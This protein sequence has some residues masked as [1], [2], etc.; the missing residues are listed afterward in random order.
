[1]CGAQL[2]VNELNI[3]YEETIN[4]GRDMRL[5]LTELLAEFPAQERPYAWY[6]Q[7]SATANIADDSLADLDVVFGDRIIRRGIWPE[8]SPDLTA[9]N[10]YLSHN[11]KGSLQNESAYRRRIERKL[12]KEVIEVPQEEIL[13]IN[14]NI[15]KQHTECVRVQ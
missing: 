8:H 9:R 1:M 6:Q 11:P 15:F 5:I 12:P 4:Y 2:I 13:R 10:F 7:T 3:F 14:S